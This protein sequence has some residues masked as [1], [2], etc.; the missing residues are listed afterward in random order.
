MKFVDVVYV[1]DNK[2]NR[3]IVE[4]QLGQFFSIETLDSGSK[5]FDLLDNYIPKV[6]ILDW[7]MPEISGLG[8][9]KKLRADNKFNSLIII[10]LTAKSSKESVITCLGAGANDYITKPPNYEEL[11]AR[12]NSLMKQREVGEH[13]RIQ[14]QLKSFESLLSGLTHEFNNI[15]AAL[16][17]SFQLFEIKG[18]EYLNSKMGSLSEHVE[19]GLKLVKTL[20]NL[21]KSGYDNFVK[22]DLKD[23]VEE[24]VKVM[25][26]NIFNSNREINI[27]LSLE[28]TPCY[29][30]GHANNLKQALYNVISNSYHATLNNEDSLIEIKLFEKDDDFYLS[31]EDNGIG[32]EPDKL[33]N[34]GQLFYTTKGSFGGEVFDNKFTG[35]GLGLP[36]TQAIISEHGGNIDFQSIFGSGT[37]VTFKLKKAIEDTISNK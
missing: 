1:D 36:A 6:L 11:V 4:K 27:V 2:L 9:L 15:F 31:V 14:N 23:I 28:K 3:F 8:I 17:L 22:L 35:T 32:I 5:L 12:I 30:N 16:K 34:L 19:R 29:I 37:L 33:K 10:M 21:K 20:H 7:M 25:R 26:N 18:P 24:A 13:T